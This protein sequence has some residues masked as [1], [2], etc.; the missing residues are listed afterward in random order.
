MINPE[1][2]KSLIKA[3]GEFAPLVKDT[4]NPFYKS[5]Y[6]PLDAVIASVMPALLNN[7][8]FLSQ[9]LEIGSDGKS[10]YLVTR[11]DHVGG[12]HIESRILLDPEAWAE[13]VK[14]PPTIE[15]TKETITAPPT[16]DSKMAART[17]TI[18]ETKTESSGSKPNSQKMAGTLT[19]LRR[20][21][22]CA[23]LGIAPQEEDDDGNSLVSAPAKASTNGVKQTPSATVAARGNGKPPTV[24]APSPGGYDWDNVAQ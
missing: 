4:A 17:E 18:T 1:M 14:L 8:L 6:A 11:L 2:V 21:Q 9:P 3:R 10:Q 5:K 24:P 20:A 22:I 13:N 16:G 19:Y 15:T 12:G 7:G 23:L